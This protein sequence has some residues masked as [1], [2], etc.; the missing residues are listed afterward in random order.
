[1][2]V[3][4]DGAAMFR[5]GNAEPSKERGNLSLRACRFIDEARQ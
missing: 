3:H 5:L 2:Q 1:M 4:R